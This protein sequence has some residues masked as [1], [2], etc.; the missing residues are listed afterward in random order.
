LIYNIPGKPNWY[1]ECEKCGLSGNVE[2]YQHS[3]GLHK[4]N[5]TNTIHKNKF[6][7]IGKIYPWVMGGWYGQ[8][9]VLILFGLFIKNLMTIYL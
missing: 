6:I 4:C 7:E 9:I 3:F 1:A 5:I 8:H 2:S